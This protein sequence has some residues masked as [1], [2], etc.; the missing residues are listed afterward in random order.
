LP[1]GAARRSDLTSDSAMLRES[2]VRRFNER[3]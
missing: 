1:G 3:D 2:V